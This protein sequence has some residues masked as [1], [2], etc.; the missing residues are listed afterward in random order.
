MGCE[1]NTAHGERPENDPADIRSDVAEGLAFIDGLSSDELRAF[2]GLFAG[3]RFPWTSFN[4]EAPFIGKAECEWVPDWRDFYG[5]RLKGAG[6][7]R[8]KEGSPHPALGMSPGSTFVDIDCG[9]TALGYDVREAWWNRLNK[10][11]K[12]KI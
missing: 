4:G 9:P 11:V 1:E 7:F 10:E 6:L 5:K 8:F 12:G 3:A 2:L